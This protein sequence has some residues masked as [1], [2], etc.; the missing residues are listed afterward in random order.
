MRCGAENKQDVQRETKKTLVDRNK[1]KP[2]VLESRNQMP[3][4]MS[5]YSLLY[6]QT[7]ASPG[8]QDNPVPKGALIPR[9]LPA[10]AVHSIL[11]ES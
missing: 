8:Q 7:P 2:E 1:S 6:W 9:D 5:I 4:K 10:P 3:Y 11:R